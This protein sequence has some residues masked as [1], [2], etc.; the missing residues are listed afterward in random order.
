MGI[1]GKRILVSLSSPCQLK[2]ITPGDTSGGRIETKPD[3]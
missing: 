3:F 1:Q 2:Q